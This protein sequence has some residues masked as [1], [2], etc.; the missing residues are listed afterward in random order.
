VQAV[1]QCRERTPDVSQLLPVCRAQALQDPAVPRRDDD[2]HL[3]RTP[4]RGLPG[5]VA[6][7]GETVHERDRAGGGG[8]RRRFGEVMPSGYASAF[9]GDG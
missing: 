1:Q 4:R 5:H 2:V 3:A 6:Q 7:G 9:L 8:M